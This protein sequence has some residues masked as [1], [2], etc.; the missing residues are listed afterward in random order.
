MYEYT[1]YSAGVVQLV[2]DGWVN[3][4]R[5]PKFCLRTHDRT[6]HLGSRVDV[7]SVLTVRTSQHLGFV[8]IF[9]QM[10][11]MWCHHDGNKNLCTEVWREE[12]CNGS[13]VGRLNSLKN[14][15]VLI[16]FLCFQTKTT[17]HPTNLGSS[18]E[19]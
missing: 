17:V 8:H 14:M 19:D 15:T 6:W 12:M 3:K 11:Q 1:P 4:R 7:Q 10:S 13:A 16:S 2:L 18:S 9:P 5:L